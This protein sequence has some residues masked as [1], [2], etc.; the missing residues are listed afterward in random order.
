MSCD[1]SVISNQYFREITGL[2]LVAQISA[3]LGQLFF[4]TRP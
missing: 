3:L 1:V 4:F 2:V